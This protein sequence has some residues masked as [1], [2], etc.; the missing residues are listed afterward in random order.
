[1]TQRKLDVPL[2]ERTLGKVL[3]AKAKQNG[4]RPYLLFEHRRYS[5]RDADS[6]SNRVARSLA[7]LGIGRNDK[8]AIFSDNRPEVLWVYFALGKLGAVAAPINTAWRGEQ[9]G[10][11]I[12]AF[13]AVALL[14]ERSLAEHFLAVQGHCPT[15][16]TV[17]LL[18]DDAA[19]SRDV[20]RPFSASVQD[21]AS[22]ERSP[23][24]AV[25]V[26]VTFKELAHIPYT[27]GTTGPSKGNLVTHCSM[28]SGAMAY[29][30]HH[31][32][33][34]S[35]VLYACLPL[36]HMSAYG[37]CVQA[38]MADAAI[39]VSRR[40]SASSFWEEIRRFGAT[41]FT[42]VGAMSNIIWSQ[43]ESKRDKDHS[44][45]LCNMIPV[46]EFA[47]EFEGR[48]GLKVVSCYGVSDFGPMTFLAPDHPP[49]KW[50]S[51]GQVRSDMTL[52][53]LDDD[54]LPV[55]PGI[56]GEICARSVLPWVAAQG[57][58]K[59]AEATASSRANFW[60]HTG[61]LGYLDTDAYLHF[62]GRKKDAIRRRGENISSYEVEMTLLTHPSVA[63]AAA[64]AVPAEIGED[65]VAVSVVPRSNVTVDPM[66][67]VQFCRDRMAYYM[68]PRY[69]D[70]VGALPKTQTQKVDKVALRALTIDRLSEVW[71]GEKHGS[72]VRRTG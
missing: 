71:D 16:R 64:Y 70:V 25:G 20:G 63:E 26:D 22:L 3:A 42:S 34:S 53:I 28:L 56:T 44:V 21:Y 67:L 19:P 29:V 46:M 12:N 30:E 24:D 62:A 31:G 8:V 17:I 11:F 60:F 61:D 18:D 39:A 32:Y 35:D 66:E 43:P 9:L 37:N 1:V 65:E 58:Y 47:R 59:A 38:L 48:F 45:R 33:E 4:E 54:D 10:H 7:A 41:Q 49:E 6:I 36:F 55:F 40:F 51:A 72:F 27:S 13:D 23:E 57:Y 52:A 5:Y 50:K 14:L 2:Q 68:V 69:V 15:V